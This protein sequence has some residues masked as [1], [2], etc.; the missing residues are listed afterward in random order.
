[1][2][3]LVLLTWSVS[4]AGAGGAPGNAAG[5]A[6]VRSAGHVARTP[7]SRAPRHVLKGWVAHSRPIGFPVMNFGRTLK[8]TLKR[9]ELPTDFA[10]C[11]DL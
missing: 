6:R 9:N 11:S 7:M 8:K 1:M 5:G 10:M 2:R 3:K 4:A